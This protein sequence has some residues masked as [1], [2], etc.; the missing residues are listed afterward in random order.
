MQ[1]FLYIET[2]VIA[3]AMEVIPPHGLGV[4]WLAAKSGPRQL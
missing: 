2:T 4:A 3:P 1:G